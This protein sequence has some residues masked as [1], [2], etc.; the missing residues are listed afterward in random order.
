MRAAAARLLHSAAPMTTLQ[1]STTK[2]KRGPRGRC[3][4]GNREGPGR[5]KG[6]RNKTTLLVEELLDN[7]AEALTRTLIK[8]A[9][10]GYAV[11]LQLVFDRLAPPRK[12]RHVTI[13]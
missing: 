2:P 9:K 4:P 8:R 3:L 1:K 10:A 6:A 12:D 13:T 7:E 5:P 11:P